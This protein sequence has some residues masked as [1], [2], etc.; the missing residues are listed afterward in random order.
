[1]PTTIYVDEPRRYPPTPATPKAVLRAGRHEDHYW[2]HLWCDGTP[3]G[4]LVLHRI[5]RKIGMRREWFQSAAKFPHYDLTPS[6]RLAALATGEVT[7]MELR[8]YLIEQRNGR[9][10]PGSFA[11]QQYNL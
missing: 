8:V 11:E 5:G 7:Q 3:E 6:R 2:C 10:Q 1:M 9:P 4:L